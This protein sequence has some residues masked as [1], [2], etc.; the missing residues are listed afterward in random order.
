MKYNEC[1][2]YIFSVSRV[3]EKWNLEINDGIICANDGG[4]S[5]GANS[6]HSFTRVEVFEDDE[7]TQNFFVIPGSDEIIEIEGPVEGHHVAK[8]VPF[9]KPWEKNDLGEILATEEECTPYVDG[10]AWASMSGEGDEL[11]DIAPE[12]VRGGLV[13]NLTPY[14]RVPCEIN[15]GNVEILSGE[16]NEECVFVGLR[17]P[18][19][20]DEV[21]AE[22]Q[23]ALE[24]ME[25]YDGSP[26]LLVQLLEK[27][28]STELKP[29]KEAWDAL[30]KALSS[31]TY[32]PDH[33]GAARLADEALDDKNLGTKII[34]NAISQVDSGTMSPPAVAM[35]DIASYAISRKEISEADK[36][37]WIDLLKS[38]GQKSANSN[39]DEIAHV[40]RSAT[41]LYEV[42]GDS[43]EELAHEIVNKFVS[44]ILDAK[45]K[46]KIIKALNKELDLSL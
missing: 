14:S 31:T 44:E 41:G 27:Y 38:A 11:R 2:V 23:E 39:I 6:I 13:I 12:Q 4:H 32:W 46:A 30:L 34:E 3:S 35:A 21:A 1:N 28:K 40:Y 7:L 25:E 19:K 36:N 9:A 26:S 17:Y 15:N 18:V 8:L 43:S 37:T 33:I 10:S 22:L 29:L 5:L 45:A 24:Y 20:E 16:P 42:L